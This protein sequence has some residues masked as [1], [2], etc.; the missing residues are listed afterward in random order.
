MNAYD[1]AAGMQVAQQIFGD[2]AGTA[3]KG[4][5]TAG[6]DTAATIK[7]PVGGDVPTANTPK[8]GTGDIAT[9]DAAK[10]PK[11]PS[12]GD[13]RD[14]VRLRKP[15]SGEGPEPSEATN[16]S[17]GKTGEIYEGDFRWR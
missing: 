1:D 16:V 3:G 7:P 15:G 8:G 4:T 14:T 12:G 6:G 10:P 2:I 5:A 13:A 9:S 11:A 17:G